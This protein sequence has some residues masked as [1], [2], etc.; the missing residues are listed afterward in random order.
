MVAGDY[1][2]FDR[3]SDGVQIIDRD[4][5]YL[6]LND[7]A[8]AHSRSERAT[9]IGRTMT[10]CYPGIE[11]TL[12][13]GVIRGVL[14][15]R[16]PA[17]TRND[18]TYADGTMRYFTLRIEPVPDGVAI[19]SC[20]VTDETNHLVLVE[21]MASRCRQV[22]DMAHALAHDLNAPLQSVRLSLEILMED[23]A[24]VLG[25]EGLVLPVGALAR[26]TRMQALIKAL[27]DHALLGVNSRLER[28][29]T[30]AIV[31]EV[32]EDLS[33]LLIQTGGEVV[34]EG[35]PAVTGYATELRVLIQNLIGNALKFAKPG[36][37][38]VVKISAVE[39]GTHMQ[40]TVADNGIG[41]VEKDRERI[42]RVFHRAHGGQAYEG[43]GIGLAHCAK[44]VALHHGRIWVES[45]PDE[46]SRFCFTLRI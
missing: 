23:Y 8:E 31:R 32:C 25:D 29:E 35:L 7:L 15:S 34:Q 44:I 38:P 13:F 43:V 5:R 16:R 39:Q 4:Y 11:G 10:E 30:S 6:Y 28:V 27:L 14:E 20:D 18:F 1:S 3:F 42:F 19:F 46:G 36:R 22:E 21:S 24:G 17:R 41:I 9:L 33:A 40:F 2:F 26:V 37:Q 45:S 12:L